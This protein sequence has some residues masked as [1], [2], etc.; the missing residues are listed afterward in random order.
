MLEVGG[1]GERGGEKDIQDIEQLVGVENGI[2]KCLGR[3]RM[4]RK[5]CGEKPE[6]TWI[7]R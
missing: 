3:G 7:A 2:E 4:F 5:V 1:G 6:M